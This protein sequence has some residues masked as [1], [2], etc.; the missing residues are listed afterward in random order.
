MLDGA[1]S[2]TAAT[3]APGIHTIAARAVDAAGNAGAASSSLAVTINTAAPTLAITSSAP[4]LRIG[5][6]ATITFSFSE[7]PGAGFD[8]A[9]IAVSGGAL[10]ALTGTGL[11]RRAVFTPSAGVDGGSASISV[12][13]GAYADLA[14]NK[15]G[16]GVLAALAFDTLAPA[17][18]GKP[19]LATASDTGAAGDGVTGTINPL[20]EGTAAPH[21]QVTLYAGATVAGNATADALG[22]WRIATALGDGSHTLTATQRDAAGNVSA[23]SSAFTLRIDAPASEPDPLVDGVPVHQQAVLLPG[24]MLGT[25]VEVPV[26]TGSR[27]ESSGRPDVADIPL[28]SDGGAALLTAQLAPGFGL[29][30]SGAS[31]P[32]AGALELLVGAI[33]AATPAHA[34]GDQGR[35]TGNGQ[36]FLAGLAPADSLLVQT[37]APVSMAAPDGMLTLAGA[38]AAP[39]R[40][41]ALVIDTAL[42]GGGTIALRDVDFAAVIGNA[43]ILARGSPVLAGDGAQQRF[44]VEAGSRAT[45]LAGGGADTLGVGM[46]DG[47]AASAPPTPAL[48]ASGSATLHGGQGVDTASFLGVRGDYDIAWH[49]GHVVVASKADPAARAMLVNVE[50]LR[51]ADGG[52]AVGQGGNMSGLE[53]L[54]GIYQSVLGRQAD[55]NGFEYWAEAI[56]AGASWGAVALRMIDSSEHSAAAGGFNGQSAHD[57]ALLYTALFNRTADAGGLAYWQDAMQHGVTLEQVA[58]ELLESVEMVGHRRAV[59]DWDVRL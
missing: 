55:L 46:P 20:I 56:D 49:H 52:L 58:L 38:P 2:I 29:R 41:V 35:L 43:D 34:P 9:D 22:H 25:S 54:A 23:P 45:V 24:G 3:L 28:A 19:A 5:Q 30:A 44:T 7:D 6:S 50:M 11:I 12:A 4:A 13:A 59:H 26:I 36:T 39:G 14:G 10:G 27:T 18:P 40:S 31:L 15:G 21:A 51:F 17:A 48:P 37:V 1:W 42:A 47:P 16:A 57:I 53:T 33:K 8:A 32:V